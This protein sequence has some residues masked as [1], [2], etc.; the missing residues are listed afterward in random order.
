[1]KSRLLPLLVGVIAVSLAPLGHAQP[2]QPVPRWYAGGNVGA[3]DFGGCPGFASCD[4]RDVGYRL[5][6]GLQLTPIIGA[7][8]GYADLGK[9]SASVAAISGSTK[10]RGLTAHA[11]G[12]WPVFD[13]T[14]IFGKLGLIYG[15][16]RVSGGF[17]S[18][19]DRGTK[20]AY[21]AG[22]RY[23]ITDAVDLS[24]EWERYRFQ[25]V[26]GGS[27]VDLF[28]VGVRVKF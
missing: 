27:D 14:S 15:E 28:S 6:G 8:F 17:G 1:M 13:R 12:S 10:A 3:S 22:V 5:F 2:T 24:G 9:T 11:I 21:G 26:G 23:A 18:R 7:E 4:T 20:L 25:T 16:S 19:K